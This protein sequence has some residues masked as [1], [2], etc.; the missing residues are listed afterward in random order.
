[1]VVTFK[2]KIFEIVR[3]IEGAS[4]MAV[5]QF[6]DVEV[7]QFLYAEDTLDGEWDCR[8]MGK[9]PYGMDLIFLAGSCPINKDRKVTLVND[10]EGQTMK[11]RQ[12]YIDSVRSCV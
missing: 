2:D 4:I 6:R 3:K 10:Y 11:G 1:M 12:K 7:Y 5:G 9:V 8:T